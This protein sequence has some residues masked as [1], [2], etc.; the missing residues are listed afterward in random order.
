M[1]VEMPRVLQYVKK[2]FAVSPFSAPA[3]DYA[4][5]FY[6]LYLLEVINGR[7]Q[8]DVKDRNITIPGGKNIPARVVTKNIGAVTSLVLTSEENEILEGVICKRNVPLRTIYSQAPTTSS[9]KLVNFR[10]ANQLREAGVK[11]QEPF[12]DLLLDLFGKLKIKTGIMFL[13]NIQANTAYLNVKYKEQFDHPYG[14]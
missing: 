10:F 3:C 7:R 14:N 6:T 13:N 8:I 5:L 9:S 4:E 1:S 12:L 2:E 11:S